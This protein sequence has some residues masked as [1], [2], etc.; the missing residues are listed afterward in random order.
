[1]TAMKRALLLALMAVAM[2]I[3]RPPTARAACGDDNC[4]YDQ[5]T[6]DAQSSYS[7]LGQTGSTC[8]QVYDNHCNYEP[9]PENPTEMCYAGNSCSYY[10]CEPGG[11]GDP[12][13]ED[14]GCHGGLC[15][16]WCE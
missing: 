13:C 1:M 10:C 4:S 7:C 9:D 11:G 16:E 5:M 12:P 3:G 6:C 14:Y 15:P 8:A 2:T